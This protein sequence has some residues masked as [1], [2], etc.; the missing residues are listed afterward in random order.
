MPTNMPLVLFVREPVLG[1]HWE[2]SSNQMRSLFSEPPSD[3]QNPKVL[4]ALTSGLV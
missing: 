1:K 3:A 2:A 4:S